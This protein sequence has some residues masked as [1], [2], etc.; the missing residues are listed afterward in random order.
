MAKLWIIAVTF[1]VLLISSGA[2]LGS[3]WNGNWSFHQRID[4]GIDTSNPIFR[5]QAVDIHI[6]FNKP[7]WA[8]NEKENS[9]R[10]VVY[11]D[12]R[13]SELESQIYNLHF[14]D[15]EHID[16]CNLVFIIP[17]FA[18]GKEKYYLYY[19][20]NRKPKSN[21]P[22]HVS[23]EKGSFYYEPIKGYSIEVS[24]CKILEDGYCVFGIGL[25]GKTVGVELAQRVVKLKRDAKEFIPKNW[26]ISASFALIYAI[27]GT[28][29][30]GTDEKL[31]SYKVL[32]DGN[33]MVR[34]KVVSESRNGN[35]R[36]ENVYTYYYCPSE[37]KRII[38][39]MHHYVLEDCTSYGPAARG[40]GFVNI[41]ATRSRSTN[42]RELNLGFIPPYV[43]FSGEDGNIKEYKLYQNPNSKTY[44]WVISPEDDADLGENAW[45]SM[46]EGRNGYAYAVVF[47]TLKGIY[48]KGR[49][50]VQLVA[51]SIE[52]IDVPGFEVDGAGISAGRNSIEPGSAKVLDLPKGL[53]INATVEFFCTYSGGYLKVE[54]ESKA[55]RVLSKLNKRV[56]GKGE[57]KGEEKRT[58]TL[59][60]IPSLQ[61]ISKPLLAILF[62]VPLPTV[63]VKLYRNES[64]VSMALASRGKALKIDRGPP[65]KIRVDLKNLTFL[66]TVKFPSVEEGDYVV[67]VFLNIGRIS[68]FVGYKVIR[69]ERNVTC[70]VKCKPEGAI[71]VRIRDQYGRKL[72]NATIELLDNGVVIAKNSSNKDGLAIIRAPFGEYDLRVIYNGLKVSEERVNLNWHMIRNYR[73]KLHDLLVKII[74]KFSLPFYAPI[75]I[76]LIHEG[77]KLRPSF[78]KNPFLFQNLPESNYVLVVG[79]KS[80]H[81][82]RFIPLHRDSEITIRLKILHTMKVKV[83]DYR[84]LVIDKGIVKIRRN[85][86]SMEKRISNGVVSF[87]L[88]PGV[89]RLSVILDGRIIA[90]TDLEILG[91]REVELATIFTSSFFPAI[92]LAL[93]IASTISSLL[94]GK[95]NL[96]SALT[97]ASISLLVFSMVSPVWSFYGKKGNYKVTSNI[98][99]LP[100]LYIILKESEFLVCGEIANLPGEFDLALW[101]VSAM[102]MIQIFLLIANSRLRKIQ[103]SLACIAI[104]SLAILFLYLVLHLS[105]G[106]FLGTVQGK[107]FVDMIMPDG[108][109]IHLLSK[110]GFGISFFSLFASLFLTFLD[111]I[112]LKFK[113]AVPRSTTSDHSRKGS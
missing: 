93:L 92:P 80:S 58:F 16:S 112:I 54:E 21:Y 46:D 59:T 71:K 38:V 84:G 25:E 95:P 61:W 4:L 15:R 57:I 82:E 32:V 108:K 70:F 91:D 96:H 34:L 28:N 27:G 79:Y 51:G 43:H 14:I 41:L 90:S 23:V 106:T 113:G 110:W 85:N 63:E 13:W 72:D 26:Q 86:F 2:S 18:D 6:R 22:D 55:F 49:E 52:W 100:P 1:L 7:C 20:Y 39:D 12:G 48:S 37:E 104:I 87:R 107:G 94:L 8:I 102:I 53:A 88:P 105:I 35:I 73:L 17:P 111:F 33:L 11:H 50:G 77:K 89:Y 31:V 103:M 45:F 67:K 9:V 56:V 83:F 30:V 44:Q 97:I 29:N 78:G 40:G 76:Y 42:I 75:S 5:N 66:Q 3:T 65:L 19:D 36:S 74:D 109:T 60:V 24:Y 10:V 99:L 81:V 64:L 98:F 62:N 69:V 47:S 68:K 101:L